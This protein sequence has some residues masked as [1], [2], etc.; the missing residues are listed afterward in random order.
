[1]VDSR[2]ETERREKPLAGSEVLVVDDEK[3]IA[4]I[5]KRLLERHGAQVIT[6][7]DGEGALEILKTKE[8][9]FTLI[10]TDRNMPLVDGPAL[11]SEIKSRPEL[12]KHQETPTIMVSGKFAETAQEEAQKLGATTG[13]SKPFNL[14]ELLDTV[15]SLIA[16]SKQQSQSST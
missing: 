15:V 8:S 10:I 14:E 6:V 16:I 4:I 13:L 11:L 7:N 2:G 1:M 5:A 3:D 9:P 12:A